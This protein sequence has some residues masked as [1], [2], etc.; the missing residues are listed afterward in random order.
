VPATPIQPAIA[1][2]PVR[3]KL[4]LLIEF[5]TGSLSPADK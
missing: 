4:A 1:S 3:T 2:A 5:L